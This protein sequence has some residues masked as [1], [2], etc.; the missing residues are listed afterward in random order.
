MDATGINYGIRTNE[1]NR[2]DEYHAKYP[3]KPIIGSENNSAVTTRGCYKSDKEVAQVLANYD[4]EV[5][6]WGSTVRDCWK[7][8]MEREW[9]AGIF[10]WTG[11][12]YRG[13]PTPFEWP[14]VSS[15]FGIM[16]TCGFAKDSFYYNK[17]CFEQKPM[18]HL[19]PHWNWK[20]GE[21]IRVAAPTNCDEA[22]LFLNGKSLGRK[23]G[24]CINTPEW[25]VE[26]V[27]GRILV[28]GYRNGKCVA[29]AEQKTAGKPYAVKIMPEMSSIKNDGAD[30][31]VIN[32]AVVDKKGVV[33]PYADNLIKFNVVGDGYVRGVGNG[34]PNSHESD[35]I[36][37]RRAFCGLC[38]ALITSYIGA[39]SIKLVAE[40]EGLESAEYEL[41][42]ENVSA[43]ICPEVSTTP[44][45]DGFTVSQTFD[46][47]PDPL[48]T[49]SDDDQN[50]FLPITFTRDSVQTDFTCGWR[51]YRAKT[52]AQ[53]DG[54]YYL[55]IDKIVCD[56]IEIFVNGKSA[57]RLS[58]S[59]NGAPM[60]SWRFRAVKGEKLDIRFLLKAQDRES[61]G[62]AGFAG[63]VC[64]ERYS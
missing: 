1:N 19:L 7:F 9:F 41:S 26:Y 4:E 43:P 18:I 55:Q 22:E 2:I 60:S 62:G 42:V 51:I 27:P 13:E 36:P 53:A 15:Q 17:A 63:P 40:S 54:E 30:T 39:E 10:I 5:V 23:S 3:D 20:K 34:D 38:Q 32:F 25:Q 11:F 61:S 21:I 57:Y 16:D 47:R 50:S 33:V 44:S 56:F 64:L 37:E 29:K 58:S 35:V 49:I 14:S 8:A 28:K 31:A 46:E 24:D 48:M 6:P 52:E 12:D 59:V 45:I